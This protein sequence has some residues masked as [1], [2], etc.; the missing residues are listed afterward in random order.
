MVNKNKNITILLGGWNNEAEVS[1]VSGEAV[2][3]SLINMGYQNVNKL[4]F[5]HDVLSKLQN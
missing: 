4:E 2:Y 5:D 1:R 3:E